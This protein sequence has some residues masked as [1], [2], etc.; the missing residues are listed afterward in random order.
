MGKRIQASLS[1]RDFEYLTVRANERGLSLGTLV[2]WIVGA[3]IKRS[4]D[5]D[6]REKDGGEVNG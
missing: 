2:R 4:R 1:E 6:M 5:R 3:W